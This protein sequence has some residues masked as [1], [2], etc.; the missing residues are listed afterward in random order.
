MSLAERRVAAVCLEREYGVSER[1]ACQVLHLP[2][3]TKRRRPGKDQQAEL[4]ARIHALSERYPR[5]GYRKIN[6]LLKAGGRAIGRERVRLIRK[7]EGLQV[8]KKAKKRRHLG[9]STAER[10][11]AQYPNHVWSYDFVYDRTVDGRTLKCLTVV[12]E[13]TRQGL[14]IHGARSVTAGDVMRV[15]RDLFARYGI[16][17]CLKSDNGPE[18]VAHQLQCWLKAQGVGTRFIDPGSP[19]QNGHNESFNAVFRA[20]CLNRWLFYSVAEARRVTEQWLDEYNHVRPHGTLNGM[21]P[22]AFAMAY[23]NKHRSAA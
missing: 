3:S 1:R 14:A 6:D 20:G 2:R 4:V 12:D 11:R 5:Y 16:P 21:T 13:F 15:L 22:S 19:W 18:L 9:Q 17:A 8:I 7:R 10:K 23:R